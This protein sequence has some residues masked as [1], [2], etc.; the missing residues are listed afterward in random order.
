MPDPFQIG[1]TYASAQMTAPDPLNPGQFITQLMREG[2]SQPEAMQMVQ[3]ATQQAPRGVPEGEMR[4]PSAPMPAQQPQM[5]QQGGLGGFIGNLFGGNERNQTIQ[6]LMGH[7]LDQGAATLYAGN[8]RLLQQ[9]LMQRQQGVKP[10]VVN[11]QLVNPSTG[12]VIGDY[13]DAPQPPTTDD[14]REYQFAKQSG[15]EGSFPDWQIDQR[16][17]GATNVT[18]GGGKYG[19]IP[20]GFELVE[21]PEGAR[22]RPIPGGPAAMEAQQ[23]EE[24][25][26]TG[27]EQQGAKA[28]Q[29]L[30]DVAAIRKDMEGGN[31]VGTFSRPFAMI[32]STPA[33]RVRSRIKALQS[34]VALQKMMDLK[35]A[36]STG[37]TGFGALSEKELSL[38][39]NEIGALDPD[40]TD[41]EIFAETLDRIEA[42][43]SR[44]LAD[45]KKNVSP[46]RIREL[47]LD[48]LGAPDPMDDAKKRL[49]EQLR[50]DGMTGGQSKKRLRWT[51][52]TGL[53][54]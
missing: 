21:T 5:G 43:Y 23:A 44:V 18:V 22:L 13:R 10:I 16:K 50:N 28:G 7:G 39:I 49:G 37:A 20:P 4:P 42:R 52:E 15:Y 29:M 34:G 47:G 1:P 12:Q 30:E 51:P 41:P 36:S 2:Y 19:T 46:E 26:Q 35:A 27:Q 11:G 3:Q 31:A 40:N 24:V 25:W 54:E 38:L 17:A 48:V 32:S 33:G 8:K 6:A 9:Y 45:I 14:I 53:Q